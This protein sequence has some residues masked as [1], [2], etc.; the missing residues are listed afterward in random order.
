MDELTDVEKKELCGTY[1]RVR[2]LARSRCHV[3]LL[4]KSFSNSIGNMEDMN[5]ASMVAIVEEVLKR[6]KL[7]AGNRK[8]LEL[9]LQRLQGWKDEL[10]ESIRVLPSEF[11]SALTVHFINACDSAVSDIEED[12]VSTN[13]ELQK[14]LERIK[15]KPEKVLADHLH[16]FKMTRG[17]K[18]SIVIQSQPHSRA[19]RQHLLEAFEQQNTLCVISITDCALRDSDLEFLLPVLKGMQHLRVLSLASNI[20][21]KASKTRLLEVLGEEHAF[22]SIQLIDLT[23]N[24]LSE[25]DVRDLHLTVAERCT[26]MKTVK[27]DGWVLGINE[28]KIRVLSLDGGGA[29]CLAQLAVLEKLESTTGNINETFDLIVGSGTGGIVAAALRSGKS[30]SDV[31]KTLCRLSTEVLT[32]QDWKVFWAF[33]AA[34][35]G[36]RSFATGDWYSGSAFEALLKEELFPD[37]QSMKDIKKPCSVVASD[38]KGREVCFRTY[39]SF[40]RQPYGN[41]PSEGVAQLGRACCATPNYLYPVEVGGVKCRDG[42]VVATNPSVLVLAELVQQVPLDR[43]CIVSVGCGTA[44][45][46]Y[47]PLAEQLSLTS[48]SLQLKSPCPPHEAL[49]SLARASPLVYHRL[50]PEPCRPH[51]ID[52]SLV[53]HYECH[54]IMLDTVTAASED[55][56]AANGDRFASIKHDIV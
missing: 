17:D 56:A 24:E 50:D 51:L 42:G 46:A 49:L 48:Q 32:T 45:G 5:I 44:A 41:V 4:R 28:K 2:D 15:D 36:V 30:L 34:Y 1:D 16:T 19:N 3:D 25:D 39:K 31:K 29:K 43:I 13:A 47:S 52:F 8:Q 54:A 18:H 7:R 21:S 20:L 11:L 35:R 38:E 22:P 6:S 12:L 53:D 27:E 55:W 37:G 14:Q 9:D 40:V 33:E 26:K 10:E 23:G